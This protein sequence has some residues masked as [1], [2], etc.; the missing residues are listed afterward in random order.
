MNRPGY[1]LFLIPDWVPYWNLSWFGIFL[2][3]R[4]CPKVTLSL[5]I[6][7]VQLFLAASDQYCN[8]ALYFKIPLQIFELFCSVPDP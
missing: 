3:L 1:G 7:K 5:F 6:D 8:M 4:F 2:N